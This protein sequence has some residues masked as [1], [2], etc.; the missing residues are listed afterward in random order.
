MTI[1]RINPILSMADIKGTSGTMPEKT[2]PTIF[3]TM[4]TF[5][6]GGT[7]YWSGVTDMKNGLGISGLGT[8]SYGWQGTWKS[9][10]SGTATVV[11]SVS[12]PAGRYVTVGH[13]GFAANGTGRRGCVMTS[14]SDGSTAVNTDNATQAGNFVPAAST[15]MTI[16]A[17]S[18]TNIF[19]ATTTLYLWAYQ[20]SGSAVNAKGLIDYIRI[21]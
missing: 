9:I 8:R 19:N 13:V 6:D 1:T 16:L 4:D 10:P 17:T 20:D 14:V 5:A 18:N 2:S 15:T 7:L 12:L 3:V 11:T 21:I